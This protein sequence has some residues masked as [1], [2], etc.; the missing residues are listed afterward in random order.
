MQGDNSREQKQQRYCI[1]NRA[2][3]IAIHHS[4]QRAREEV[5]RQI[6]DDEELHRIV[7]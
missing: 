3:L 4:G 2:D 1:E 6:G 5:H 7:G